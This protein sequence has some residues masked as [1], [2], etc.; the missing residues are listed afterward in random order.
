MSISY[1][2]CKIWWAP[3]VPTRLL[4]SKGSGRRAQGK[5][6]WQC[7]SPIFSCKMGSRYCAC[8]VSL[9]CILDEWSPCVHPVLRTPTLEAR[10][11]P[12]QKLVQLW[13]THSLCGPHLAPFPQVV[14]RAVTF[15]Q[16]S[17]AGLAYT[18]H[19]VNSP[20]HSCRACLRV[21]WGLSWRT[22]A[23]Q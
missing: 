3:R 9:S 5:L 8:C 1:V 20:V 6:K 13:E 7:S 22:D 11:K 10:A 19:P 17:V 4:F 12:C 21:A 2:P 15:C 18:W 16:S 14:G 23:N